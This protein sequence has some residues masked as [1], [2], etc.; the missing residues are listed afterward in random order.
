ML[1]ASVL[2]IVLLLAIGQ[3]AVLLC[4]GW[5]HP[6]GSAM[7]ECHE[8]IQGSRTVARLKGGDGCG[9]MTVDAGVFVKEDLRRASDAGGWH[10]AVVP[11]F[12]APAPAGTERQD[13][14]PGRMSVPAARRPVLALRI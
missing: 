12:H 11:R 1:R 4:R 14:E 13:S 7:A 2:A 9:R 5:C 8:R 6:A 3:D 10:A